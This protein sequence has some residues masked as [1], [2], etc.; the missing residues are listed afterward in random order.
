MI[1]RLDTADIRAGAVKRSW[2]CKMPTSENAAPENSTV[3]NS[4]RV[5]DTAKAVVAGSA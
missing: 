2:A 1:A 3:G 4:T 5:R